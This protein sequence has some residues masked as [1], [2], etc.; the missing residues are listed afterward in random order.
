M[1][2]DFL[3][4]AQFEPEPEAI[5]EPVA[6]TQ[7]EPTPQPETEQTVPLAALHEER[8]KSRNLRD[9]IPEL[10]RQ[11]AQ[12]QEVVSRS[13]QSPPEHIDPIMEPEKFQAAITSQ[14]AAQVSN[15]YLEISE[16]SA[17][18]QY[19]DEAINAA[20]EAAQA[21][22]AIE[23]FRGK[24]DAWGDLAKWH[25][26]QQAL[27]TIGDDPA[28]YAARVEAEVRQKILAEMAAQSVNKS[29][30]SLAGATNLGS[31][32]APAWQGPTPL[33]DI[34]GVKSPGY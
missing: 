27:A 32:A 6:E 3:Q 7:P 13:Q 31:R 4:P 5:A 19:G 9:T 1:E 10:Q 28:A 12:L 26:S 15:V 16:R 8:N 20:L 11:I 18:A 33:E 30:P 14:V 29:A 34:L 25:K 2:D 21:T 24:K 17:R 23:Q 22:G